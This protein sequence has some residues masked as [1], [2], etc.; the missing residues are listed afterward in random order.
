MESRGIIFTY[1]KLSI[2]NFYYSS[3]FDTFNLPEDDDKIYQVNNEMA[4]RRLII[5]LNHA[6]DIVAKLFSNQLKKLPALNSD[7]LLV[8]ARLNLYRFAID[9]ETFETKTYQCNQTN[10]ISQEFDHELFADH[11]NTLI[12]S[13]EFDEIILYAEENLGSP[14]EVMLSPLAQKLIHKISPDY[15]VLFTETE[16]LFKTAVAIA[17]EIDLIVDDVSLT[18]D[19]FLHLKTLL[20]DE[21]FVRDKK[22]L[23]V[24]AMLP[25]PTPGMI[26]DS[27]CL[28][29]V[30]LRRRLDAIL[31][32]ARQREQTL[33]ISH[34]SSFTDDSIRVSERSFSGHEDGL[35]LNRIHEIPRQSFWSRIFLCAKRST[36]VVDETFIL[37]QEETRRFNFFTEIKIVNNK[38]YLKSLRL[39]SVK[40]S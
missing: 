26:T 17:N 33:S 6:T 7:D 18:K 28:E 21:S 1:G 4:M 22:K 27:A 23:A 10:P 25:I 2:F 16:A 9:S 29:G 40:P 5:H 14:G 34:A 36:K 37:R 32:R 39:S 20:S 19:V 11:I 35:E 3:N 15:L 8:V 38:R 31:S 24:N 12:E 30:R 13:N